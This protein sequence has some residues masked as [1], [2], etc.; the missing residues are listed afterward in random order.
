MW[1][2]YDIQGLCIIFATAKNTYSKTMFIEIKVPSVGESITEVTLS[3]IIAP[4]GSLVQLDQVLCEFESDKTN[5]ELS[6]E[7]AGIVHYIAQEGDDLPI[8]ALVC[9]ID[10]TASTDKGNSSPAPSNVEK[11]TNTQQKAGNEEDVVTYATGHASPAAAKL[12]AENNLNPADIKGTGIDGRITKEDV[13]SHI[14][15]QKAAAEVKAL[16]KTETT[17]PKTQQ[18]T[19]PVAATSLSGN[20]TETREKMSR[21]RKTIAKRLVDVKNNTAM[22]TTF[23]EVDM[24]A[25]FDLRKKYKESFEKKYGIGLGFMSLFGKAAAMALLEFP[26]VNAYLNE[27]YIEY[28]NY[29]DI[30]I[31]VST[32]RGLV[33]PVLR[34][35]E[36]MSLQDI[37]LTIKDL[38]GKA[39]NNTLSIDDMSGGTFTITNGGIF[40]SL[41]STPIINP[42]QSAILGMHSIQ[43]R[44]VA[45]NGQVVIRPMMYVAL[46][47]DHR[48]IDGKEAVSFL[49]RIKQYLED[50][51]RLMLQV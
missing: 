47:Y 6:A 32:D 50:P 19:P 45:L 43:E 39:R 33:V 9:T 25:I 3:K 23:N 35:V 2:C 30:S 21:L 4:E 41:L 31:A 51:I 16:A 44:P 38:A 7:A 28:H 12:I 49:V 8:G 1:Y 29:A 22:L 48:I 27:D 15:A 46:S 18:E 24:T 13:A 11:S 10:A 40:G 34:N 37:E 5:F 14:A 17:A 26:A 20:R 42:P 36:Q